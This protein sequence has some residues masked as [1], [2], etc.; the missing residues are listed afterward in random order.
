[1]MDKSEQLG[2]A[3]NRASKMR[4]AERA[5]L[6]AA[7]GLSQDAIWRIEHTTHGIPTD[8]AVTETLAFIGALAALAALETENA[9]D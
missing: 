1:M 6:D 4:K 8:L 5:V 2:A 3:L 9:K 7:K